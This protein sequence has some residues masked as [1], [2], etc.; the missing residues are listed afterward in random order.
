MPRGYFSNHIIDMENVPTL[1]NT[2]EILAVSQTWL[3][4]VY[5]KCNKTEG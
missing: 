4:Q 2:L 3:T 1:R 5:L